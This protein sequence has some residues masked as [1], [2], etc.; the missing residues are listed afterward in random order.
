MYNEIGNIEET[1]REAARI[2][3]TLTRDLE[4]V[5]VDDASTDGSGELVESLKSA[6]PELV[7]IHHPVNRKLGGALKTGFGAATGEWIL[8]IDSDLPIRMDDI[9]KAIPLT[10][11]AD[12]VIG[13]R[14]SRAESL[15]R[16]IMSKAYNWL[17]RLLFGLKVRD[18]NFSFKLFRRSIL[19]RIALQ[20]EGSFIDAELLIE[21]FRNGYVIRETGFKYHPRKAGISTLASPS[22]VWKILQEMQAYRRRIAARARQVREE[23]AHR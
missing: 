1:V 6:Y 19:E 18:I 10:D 14:I 22:I 23:K 4:I 16:E 17:I 3:R 2:G 5:V 20:S 12:M 7:V 15:K 9:Y 8:Y 21:T 13:Y 11:E